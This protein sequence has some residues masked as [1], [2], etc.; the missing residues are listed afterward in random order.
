MKA[1]IILTLYILFSATA[2]ANTW[3]QQRWQFKVAHQALL[4]KDFKTFEQVSAQLRDYPIAHYLRYFYLR[5]H[6]SENRT[7]KAFLK[8][9]KNSPIAN[10]L[11]QAWLMQLAKKRHWK[12]FIAAYTP[13]KYTILRCYH[14]QARL[15]RQGNLKGHLDEAKDLWLVGNSQPDECNP[16]FKYLYD[17]KLV[18]KKM[19]WQRISL[20]MQKGNGKLAHF[21]AKGLPKTDRQL[22]S[23]W[24]SIYRKPDI[25]LKN[26][27]HR[28]TPIVREMLLQGLK[29]LARKKA[30]TA[31]MYWKKYQKRYA[32]TKQ[33]NAELFQYIALKSAEQMHSRAASWLDAVDLVNDQVK[34]A[35]LQIALIQQDWSSVKKL[36]KPFSTDK[37]WQYWYARALEQTGETKKAKKLF[38]QLSQNRNFYG[39]LAADRLGK[40]YD[41]QSQPL[42]VTKSKQEQLLDKNVGLIRARELFLIGRPDLA[43][44]EWHAVLPSLSTDELKTAAT[45]AH[46]WEW[47]DQAII[48][49]AKAEYYND[50]KIRFPIPFYDEILT[51]AQAQQLDYAF[52]YAVIRQE[53][54]FQTDIRS[55]AGALGLMQLMPTTAKGVA[56]KQK[57]RLK[58][59]YNLVLPDI[60]ILNR[61]NGNH[62]LATAAYNAGPTRAKR[63]VKK[64]GCLPQDIWVELIPFNE[65]RKYVQAVL[66]YAPIFEYQ[67]VG[68]RQIKSMQLD[69]IKGGKC[70]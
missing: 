9:H 49:I 67:L 51:H 11:R 44:L 16:V 1:T 14:L 35:R 57:M 64:Y 60:N 24:R 22:V 52:V 27:E 59:T 41:F 46:Q 2:Q 20:S 29:R 13:Q 40:L 21:I 54:A 69:A 36:S 47:H 56:K 5:S 53:S 37:K 12:T 6:L 66:S 23:T 31:Y 55:S 68:H 19:R 3:L 34:Q 26:F 8:Q 17:H 33:E 10:S 48:T 62:M 50:L 65:T 63:W 32:F 38:D 45:L 30:G 61:F 28:D 58:N 7:I 4:N 42:K 18:T 15:H 70:N 25:I 39:F 43:R